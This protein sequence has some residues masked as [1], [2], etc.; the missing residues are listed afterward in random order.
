[1]ISSSRVEKVK[2]TE[3]SYNKEYF[4]AFLVFCSKIGLFQK[5]PSLRGNY[6][7]LNIVK[8][9]SDLHSSTIS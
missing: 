4:M 8:C 3:G 5:I 9:H 7:L 2:I 1:M 6:E